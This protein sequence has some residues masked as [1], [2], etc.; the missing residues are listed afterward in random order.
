MDIFYILFCC[1]H[2]RLWTSKCWLG[3]WKC[4]WELLYWKMVEDKTFAKTFWCLHCW[5]LSGKYQ[6]DGVL[7]DL[8]L[9]NMTM[10][11]NNQIAKND[12]TKTMYDR[13]F[14]SFNEYLLKMVRH[15]LEILQVMLQQFLMRLTILRHCIHERIETFTLKFFQETCRKLN[16]L[17]KELLS[18]YRFRENFQ[19]KRG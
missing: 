15:T 7:L 17:F 16:K 19:V 6:L 5:F 2:S 3:I 18:C 11:H 10:Q 9:L 12:F 4:S 1:F 8:R 14:Y 13:L